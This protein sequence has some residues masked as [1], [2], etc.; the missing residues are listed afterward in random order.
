MLSC[1]RLET[2]GV[3]WRKVAIVRLLV[4]VGVAV[5]LISAEPSHAGDCIAFVLAQRTRL[6][7]VLTK[8]T[9]AALFPRASGVER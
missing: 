9:V 2:T 5:V 7:D 1:N 3:V 8:H 6:T 4:F